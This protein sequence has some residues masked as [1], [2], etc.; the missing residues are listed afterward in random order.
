MRVILATAV[1]NAQQVAAQVL[2]TYFNDVLYEHDVR[3]VRLL[4]FSNVFNYSSGALT[5]M[6]WSH[7]LIKA[8]YGWKKTKR[9]LFYVM[10]TCVA[11]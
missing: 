4:D 3:K 10:A 8:I 1:A 11:V 7:S 5:L 6:P 2:R 9:T